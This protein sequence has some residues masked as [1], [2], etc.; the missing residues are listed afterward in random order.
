MDTAVR[1]LPDRVQEMVISKIQTVW[2]HQPEA[3]LRLVK[4]IEQMPGASAKEGSLRLSVLTNVLRSVEKADPIALPRTAVVLSDIMTAP[5]P[6]LTDIGKV[7]VNVSRAEPAVLPVVLDLIQ[8]V[9]ARQPETLPVIA[10]AVN[11]IIA[12]QPDIVAQSSMPKNVV[13]QTVQL[14]ANAANSEARPATVGAL[15]A[16][17]HVRLPAAA[18]TT[19]A[20]GPGLS[21]PVGSR[22]EAIATAIV[23]T[24]KEAPQVLAETVRT[25]ES[26]I[27]AES[28]LS[29][30]KSPMASGHEM[31]IELPTPHLDFSI[32]TARVQTEFVADLIKSTT[33]PARHSEPLN[34]LI[35]AVSQLGNAKYEAAVVQISR[36]T[37]E[38]PKLAEPLVRL[39]TQVAVKNVEMLPVIT[40]LIPHITSVPEPVAAIVLPALETLVMASRPEAMP[41]MSA[42]QGSFLERFAEA[43]SE[44]GPASRPSGYSTEF[45]SIPTPQS[46][47]EQMPRV[48]QPVGAERSESTVAQT[49]AKPIVLASE[50]PVSVAGT[51]RPST[52]ESQLVTTPQFNS[53]AEAGSGTGTPI[54]GKGADTVPGIPVGRPSVG[55]VGAASGGPVSVGSVG[56]GSIGS[57]MP[58][59]A[60]FTQPIPVGIRPTQPIPQTVRLVLGDSGSG[61]GVLMPAEQIQN[62]KVS[63]QL[64]ALVSAT[65]VVADLPKSVMI[66]G[67]T[68]IAS[69]GQSGSPALDAVVSAVSLLNAHP[70]ET[71]QTALSILTSASH[72]SADALIKVANAITELAKLVPGSVKDGL[73]LLKQVE[74]LSPRLV[75]PTANLISEIA[76][77]AP[78]QV[79][80]AVALIATIGES[81]LP[82]LRLAV[83][84]LPGLIAESPAN[85]ESTIK[86]I[87]SVLTGNKADVHLVNQ[88]IGAA[89]RI[90]PEVT[91]S[92]LRIFG[93]VAIH[94]ADSI[95]NFSEFLEQLINSGRLPFLEAATGMEM[96]EQEAKIRKKRRINP[97]DN[98]ASELK[99]TDLLASLFAKLEMENW[100]LAALFRMRLRRRRPSKNEAFALVNRT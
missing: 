30:S 23:R 1:Q 21:L 61:R 62:A 97:I 2:D 85:A 83:S 99:S 73:Q 27:L 5:V 26:I 4:A 72:Q 90:N 36:L 16:E 19:P 64:L 94:S 46:S 42:F 25:F 7:I 13:A 9:A 69:L 76:H 77:L 88:L 92:L 70:P 32:H 74:S 59:S 79:P 37:V 31:A 35:R 82:A 84:I 78:K 45:V 11:Q 52:S 17:S 50:S 43:R 49:V 22:L 3:A 89:S 68:L 95:P 93:D 87:Q 65:K 34:Q 28:S 38:H 14:L 56:V 39:V 81:G 55:H 58:A 47:G 53:R 18:T 33:L 98:E 57:P 15:I 12:R 20:S 48:S 80:G 51:A 75:A 10:R 6:H 8:T 54:I 71:I 91:P 40:E 29:D 24:A 86:A 41:E 66:Q 100:E 96:A 44:S 63:A 60:Q 67:A